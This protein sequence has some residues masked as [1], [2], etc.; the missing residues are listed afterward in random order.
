MSDSFETPMDCTPPGSSIHRISQAKIL[1]RTAIS[2]SRA[3]SKL[4]DQGSGYI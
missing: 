3:S 4:R 2:F 1:E